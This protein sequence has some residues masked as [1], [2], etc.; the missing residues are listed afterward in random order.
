MK[1]NVSN[2]IE[3]EQQRQELLREFSADRDPSEIGDYSPGSFGCHELL[4][5]TALI[6]CLLEEHIVEHPAC[7]QHPDWFILAHEATTIL[8]RLYQEV[9]RKHL[10]Q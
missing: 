8:N 4:D 7:F 2:S 6:M 1:P 3:V 9:G 5:R 10:T